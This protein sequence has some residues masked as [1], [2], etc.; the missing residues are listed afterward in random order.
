ML[1]QNPWISGISY[2]GVLSVAFRLDTQIV[3][4]QLN[5]ISK[6]HPTYLEA[7]AVLDHFE[8]FWIILKVFFEKKY[9]EFC[10]KFCIFELTGN[11]YGSER[12]V[13]RSFGTIS[14]VYE[15]KFRRTFHRFVFS[16][17]RFSCPSNYDHKSCF[18]K[19]RDSPSIIKRRELSKQIV[20][21]Q[22]LPFSTF[23]IYLWQSSLCHQREVLLLTNFCTNMAAAG[24]LVMVTIFHPCISCMFTSNKHFV[25]NS[26]WWQRLTK[27]GN[28][29]KVMWLDCCKGRTT[30][31]TRPKL[32]I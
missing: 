25:C 30:P 29:W 31:E 18:L 17:I 2:I 5:F 4:Y 23:Q 28:F 10:L 1:A 19:N 26:T 27:H 22:L 16:R 3:L 7:V 20:L 32:H 24:Q 14:E 21:I 13:F 9:P 12:D 6:D 15:K 11:I 8:Q